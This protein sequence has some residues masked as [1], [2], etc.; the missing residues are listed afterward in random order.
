MEQIKQPTV[1]RKSLGQPYFFDMRS[2]DF[3]RHRKAV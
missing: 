2:L 3:I 1:H